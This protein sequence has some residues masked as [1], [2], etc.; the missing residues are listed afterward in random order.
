MGNHMDGTSLTRNDASY[1]TNL[2]PQSTGLNQSGGSWKET[3][4]LIECH[5]DHSDVARLEIFGGLIY[6]DDTNDYFIESHGIPTPDTYYKVVVKYFKD[7][8]V[9]PDVIAWVMENKPTD[10][11]DRLDMR[12]NDGGDL[13]AVK[14]LKRLVSDQLALLPPTF[15]ETAF[16]SGSS[17]DRD[18]TC[19]RGNLFKDEL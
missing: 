8:S 9:L 19:Y 12:Y 15:S 11:A 6:D 16:E 18:G 10:T 4:D 13:I 5:R 3:E 1:A 17:W 14:Q 2:V 7:S